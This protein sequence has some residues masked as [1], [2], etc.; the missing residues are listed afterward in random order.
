M[1]MVNLRMDATVV[2][3]SMIIQWTCEVY[4]NC[5]QT[6]FDRE[7]MKVFSTVE[8]FGINQAGLADTVLQML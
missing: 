6:I 4:S 2:K 8:T 3:E 1:L 7:K 5:I